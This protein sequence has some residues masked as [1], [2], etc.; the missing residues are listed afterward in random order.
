[1]NRLT[2]RVLLA[3]SL[4]LSLP[5][6]TITASI[7]G[8]VSD[9]SGAAIPGGAVIATNTETNVRTNT[10]VNNE[11]IYTFPFLRVGKYTVTVEAKGFKKSVVGPFGVEA[12]QIA[13][14]DVKLE[15]GDITQT[16]EVADV[17][18]ILQ[19]ETQA[20]GDTL[21]STKLTSIPL[22]GRNFASLT[23][24]IPGAVSTSP[25]AMNTAA[26]F[27]GSGSRPQVNGNRE[28]T[29]NFILDG[30]DINQSVDNQIG[31]Q[32]NVDALEEVKVVTGNA[33]AE[34]GNVGGA[35]VVMSIKSGT[36]EYHG[37]LF[38][39][40]RNEKLD[41]T[42]FFNNRNR[43]RKQALR[44]NIFGG[45][46]GG[47]IKKN[48]TF[49]FVDYEQ[50]ERRIAGPATASVAPAAWRT[51]D[52]SQILLANASQLIRDPLSGPSVATRTPFPNNQV[53]VARF[54]ATARALFGNPA[55]YPLPN[56]VGTGPL[57]IGGNYIGATRNYLSNKQ[58]DLKLDHRLSDK[59]NLT[60]RFSKG[61]YETFGSQAALPVNMTS[62]ND[63]PTWSAVTSW[64]RTWNSQLVSD[65]RFSYSLVGID[66]KVIDWSGQ[67]GADGNSKFG[68]PGGQFIA[69]LSSFNLGS[70]LSGVGSAA[71]IA[72]TR[73]NK[74]QY[75]S[76]NTY[77]TGTHLIKAG[78]NL[79]RMRQNR[80]YAGNNGALGSFSYSAAYTGVDTGDFLLDTLS[81]KG[82]G[83][84]SGPWGHRGWR[85]I[86]FAQDSWKIR[87]NVTFNYGLS[88]EYTSP[89]YE[90]ADRQVNINTFTGEL[91]YPGG[92][93]GRALYNAYKKQFN[94]NLGLAWSVNSKTVVRAAYRLSNFLEG[95]GANLRLTLNPPFFTESN[96][97]YDASAPG[98]ISTGFTDVIARGDL[99]SQRSSPTAAPFYQGRAWDLN[100]RPQMTNQFNFAIERQIDSSTNVNIA[101]V[102]QRGT[103]LVIPH[104]G[105]NPVR[106]TGPYADA[107]GRVLWA[108]I[109]DRRPLAKVLPNVGNIAL[110]E[111][112]GTSWYNALQVSGRRRMTGGIE[113]LFQ[114][115]YS[116]TNTDGLGYYGCGGVSAEG[117][118]WQDAYNRRANYGPA[119]FDVR[120]NF[121]T[122][123]VWNVPYGKGQKFGASSNKVVDAVLGGW[124]VS[125]NLAKRGGFPVSLRAGAHNVNS[126]RAPRGNV[127]PNYY[128]PMAEPSVRTVDRWFG[129]VSASTFCASGVDNGTCAYGVPAGGE[130]G[131]AGV[132]TERAPGFFN[133][134]TSFGKTFNVTEK[135]R[136]QF[137]AEMFNILNYVAWGNP[138][139]DITAPAS[140][141]TIT[142][143]IGAPRNIQFALKYQF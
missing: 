74:F 55:L 16:V 29:N 97:A 140:F 38:E 108:P 62:G 79:L 72:N 116:K 17:G 110:T 3:L 113:M 22:N 6:Q 109:D 100:L 42:G 115:T 127:R 92:K 25:G 141:G 34:F 103:H 82:R 76:N 118:Y 14:I 39:F 23:L 89:I 120:H 99:T 40:L 83:A 45:T 48:R 8:S 135:H 54:S 98:R 1:M 30:V 136:L 126:G 102:G 21:S 75:Q 81:S 2:V 46:F 69:G 84:V 53:P 18:P 131:S 101:Y 63:G 114:Y 47:A 130:L 105:N 61:M 19:T 73:D 119:C 35:S 15:L 70:G 24:L 122:A 71:T 138:G 26:R 4:A 78:V 28:Q 117:A 37:N 107:Q 133:L 134:D 106:G 139:Q 129:D 9:P 142:S 80:Y 123:G 86:I 44:Q 104:E 143:Q 31:Y 7:T 128:R 60:F 52:L 68:I 90:V 51:G 67:L 91:I 77:Q 59:D 65:N 87:R 137:R 58:G 112:S 57:G 96:I 93:F 88:W 56:N 27:Q 64:T 41:A 125:Y 111:S 94:P 11:G 121:T 95:T 85:N 32:P 12:N 20:T 43:V 5:A 10:T 36:N 13:R 124:N 66:D 132:G 49:F 33:G 50:T